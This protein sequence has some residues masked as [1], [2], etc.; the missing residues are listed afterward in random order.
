MKRVMILLLVLAMLL[1]LAGPAMADPAEGP[2]CLVPTNLIRQFTRRLPEAFSMMANADPAGAM[3]KYLLSNP[4]MT[5][6]GIQFSNEDGTVRLA[7][8]GG[9][10]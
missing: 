4:G 6:E 3:E 2:A 7:A 8:R 5:G 1:S 9:T 10:G